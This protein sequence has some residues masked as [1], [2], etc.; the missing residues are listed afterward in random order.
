M[1]KPD[2][3]AIGHFRDNHDALLAAY[4]YL[5]RSAEP[6]PYRTGMEIP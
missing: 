5:G 1:H 4:V 2:S 6:N 3:P